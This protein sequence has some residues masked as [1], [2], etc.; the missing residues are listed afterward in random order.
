ML[1]IAICDDEEYF[2]LKEQEFI[3]QYLSK[4]NQKVQIDRYASGEELLEQGDA[5][6]KYDIIFLD[7]N[8]DRLDG[9]ETARRIRKFSNRNFIVFVTAFVQYAVN[10]YEVDAV[11]CVIKDE[12]YEDR[13]T[14]CMDA[15]LKRI[16]GKKD[17][18]TLPFQEGTRELSLANLV[19]V[20]S[21]LH[22]LIFHVENEEAKV[23]T[24]YE[25]L[26]KID[27]ILQEAGFCRT[28]QSFL[29]NLQYIQ[30]LER[31]S[32]WLTDGSC[33]GISKARYNDAMNR[34]ICYKGEI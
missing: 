3:T 2:C 5:V 32:V 19:Y 28:H 27:E 16:Q 34:W 31:Y 21:Q 20:E 23:Y 14:E 22:K 11:R 8:M 9:V 29:V 1:F 33:L 10:G 7:V 17:T 15:I 13:L 24:M 25:K 30:R 18:I 26:D 4:K 6:A 12:R